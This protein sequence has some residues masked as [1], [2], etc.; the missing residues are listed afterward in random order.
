M[1]KPN[2][3][4]IIK[5]WSQ[6]DP[7]KPESIAQF[8]GAMDYFMQAPELPEI[9]GAI[10]HYALEGDFPDAQR[11]ILL[12]TLVAPGDY[13]TAYE[14]VFAIRDYTGTR[15]SGMDLLDV[16]SGAAIAKVEKGSRAIINKVSGAKVTIPFV[17]YGG[18]L[19]WDK[20]L[21]S[22][23]DYWS[24]E[25]TAIAFRTE[26]MQARS[27]AYYDIIDDQ[28]NGVT[29]G[30][31]LAWQAV[32]PAS[33]ANTNRDY[34]AVRD[35]NT[36]NAACEEIISD[37]KNSGFGITPSSQFV[38]L[39]PNTLKVRLTQALGITNQQ[40]AGASTYLGYNVKLVTSLM[41]SSSTVYY[42]CLP[43]RKTVGGYRQDLTMTPL[44]D[45]LANLE[46][47]VGW[48]RFAGAIG[49]E[50]QFQRCSIA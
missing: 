41:L 24:V 14:E 25:D 42:V 23:G 21:M 5:D 4:R 7:A 16:T 32:T 36:I 12:K 1:L 26:S 28:T 18:G 22:D 35:V 3:G 10:Q 39:A 9:K 50:E 44:A 43:G 38:I 46:G 11:E 47:A 40:L 8:Y 49:E 33:Y 34:N 31:D 6:V 15:A 2:Q 48:M 20:N 30:Q 27:Q 13:D 45:P 37:L 19:G 29:S 17:D